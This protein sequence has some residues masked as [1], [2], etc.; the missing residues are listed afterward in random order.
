MV[1]SC[2]CVVTASEYTMSINKRSDTYDESDTEIS[3]NNLSDG[4]NGN[5]F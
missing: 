4:S 5:V 1:M 3:K 2:N